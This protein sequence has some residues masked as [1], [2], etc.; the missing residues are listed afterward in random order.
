MR[1]WPRGAG[2]TAARMT[3]LRRQRFRRAAGRGDAADGRRHRLVCGDSTGSL[4]A[5]EAARGGAKRHLMVTDPP[6]GVEHDPA[7]RD[8]AGAAATRRTGTVLN[9]D[10]ARLG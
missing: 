6:Y 4:G 1:C 2:L 8:K 5:V 7:W 3:R 10:R 9:D